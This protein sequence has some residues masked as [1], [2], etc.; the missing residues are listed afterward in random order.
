MDAAGQI[1]LS[2]RERKVVHIT[3]QRQRQVQ[4]SVG[5]SLGKRGRQ[6][7]ARRPQEV[8]LGE[9]CR[10]THVQSPTLSGL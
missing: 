3:R 5:I 1:S 2:L 8:G 4:Q 6:H 7:I 9:R 10:Q